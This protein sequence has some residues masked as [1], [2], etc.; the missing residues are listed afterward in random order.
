MS[1]TVT[2][3]VPVAEVEDVCKK[4]E[5]SSY[6]STEYDYYDGEDYGED[7]HEEEVWD[8]QTE[9]PAATTGEPAQT[10][11]ETETAFL[12]RS[13]C[14]KCFNYG[15]WEKDCKK[16]KGKNSNGK[17]AY[18]SVTPS[19]FSFAAFFCPAAARAAVDSGCSTSCVSAATLA[20]FEQAHPGDVRRLGNSEK[21]EVTF[22]NGLSAA[23]IDVCEVATPLGRAAFNVYD[24][25]AEIP[26]FLLGSDFL[27]KQNCSLVFA[28]GGATLKSDI[29]KCKLKLL[30]ANA[31][32]LPEASV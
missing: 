2:D 30:E 8:G 23:V 31:Y 15:H 24:N 7:G 26:A 25:S 14:R 18:V 32:S 1:T 3:V 29:H 12:A 27:K 16:G 4:S 22:G 13:Q 20:K 19:V 28:S 6:F 9:N 10:E 11:E 17:K 21:G 5:N